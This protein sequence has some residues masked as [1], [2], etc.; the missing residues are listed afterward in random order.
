[1]RRSWPGFLILL[2]LCAA[3]PAHAQNAPANG[4][5]PNWSALSPGNDWSAT[6]INNLFPLSANTG[7]SQIQSENT[8]VGQILGQF[9]GFIMALAAAWVAYATIIQIHRAAETGRVLSNTTSSWAPVRLFL[10]IIMMFPLSTGF[11][12]GQA[13]VVQ[14]AMWGIGMAKTIYTNAVQSIGPDAMPIA[15]PIIPGTHGV[16]AG[17]MQSE[18]CRDLVNLASGNSNLVPEPAPTTGGTPGVGGYVTWAYTLANGDATGQPLCGSI[19]IR[20]PGQ[21]PNMAGVNVN[22]A[23]QQQTA[24]TQV[25]SQIIAP[26]AQT[27]AQ[28]SVANASGQRAH[29][30]PERLHLGSPAIHRAAHH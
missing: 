5:T 12:A 11:S 4:F 10:A 24:L 17:L 8:V 1:M 3:L 26:A 27:A 14:V 6:I 15:T 29:A 9:T 30:A 19:T 20:E 28:N 21:P 22:M 2:L 25:L 16:V 23:Q 7:S 18:I 13:A